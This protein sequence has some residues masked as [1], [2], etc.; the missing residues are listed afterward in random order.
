[1]STKKICPE[2]GIENDIE[3]DKDSGDYCSNCERSLN[4]D[5]ALLGNDDR[6]KLAKERLI[7]YIN[8]GYEIYALFGYSYSGKTNFLYA[9]HQKLKRGDDAGFGYYSCTELNKWRKMADAVERAHKSKQQLG[10][11]MENFFIYP[12]IHRKKK[13]NI[14]FIDIAGAHF[15]NPVNWRVQIDDFIGTYLPYCKGCFVFLDVISQ[16]ENNSEE[17]KQLNKNMLSE[18]QVDEQ[19]ESLVNFLTETYS[20]TNITILDKPVALCLSKADIIE[21]FYFEELDCKKVPTQL[22]AARFIQKYWEGH[23]NSI[24]GIVPNLKI[25]W[26][27]SLG[28]D[29]KET[30]KIGE[31]ISL[32][33]V[34][35]FVVLSPPPPWAMS[36]KTYYNKFSR[37]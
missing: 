13:R 30:R 6:F 21:D 1:M 7:P 9:L 36:F 10:N 4:S 29:F 2:C 34:F 32:K 8:E 23:F 37:K 17:E 24:M 14:L 27:S 28:K 15:Q 35:D 11:E 16:F 22:S 26:L 33:S 12:A 3:S 18:K 31:P 20:K 19:F 25:E 5:K